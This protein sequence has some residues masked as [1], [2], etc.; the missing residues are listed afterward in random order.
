M[1]PDD[2]SKARQSLSRPVSRAQ[3]KG[4]ASRMTDQIE[5]WRGGLIT[6]DVGKIGVPDARIRT[7][8]PLGGRGARADGVTV[9]F[10]VA[11][12]NGTSKLFVWIPPSQYEDLVSA[13][14]DGGSA[15]AEVAFLKQMLAKRRAKAQ[16][17]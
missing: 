13:M 17:P 9:T 15:E 8:L 7:G 3:R 5:V 14:F 12:G 4:K 16:R 11:S 10:G 1:T 6:G 2:T